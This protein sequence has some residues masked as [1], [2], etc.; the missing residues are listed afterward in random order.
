MNFSV[1]LKNR[2]QRCECIIFSTDSAKV[3]KRCV[4]AMNGAPCCSPG[5]DHADIHCKPES[6]KNKK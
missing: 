1:I 2:E 5:C 3:A 6:I 4:E